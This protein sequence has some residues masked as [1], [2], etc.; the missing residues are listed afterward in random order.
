M[1]VDLLWGSYNRQVEHPLAQR[2]TVALGRVLAER[3]FGP[4]LRWLGV[5][6]VPPRAGK[7]ALPKPAWRYRGSR[8]E[9]LLVA[10]PA[11]SIGDLDD[12]E[13]MRLLIAAV[14]D[15]MARAL[16]LLD[17]ALRFDLT[18]ATSAVKECLAGKV[19]AL[20][21]TR[22][23][24]DLSPQLM[25]HMA[26][27]TRGFDATRRGWVRPLTHRL[28][29]VRIHR[30][31]G[32]VLGRVDEDDALVAELLTGALSGRIATPGYS[33]IYVNVGPDADRLRFERSAL[34]DWCENAYAVVDLDALKRLDARR[35]RRSVL[36]SCRQAL[37]ELA[38]VDHLD[39][40]EILRLTA[41]LDAEDLG[42]VFVYRSET[43]G[44]LTVELRYSLAERKDLLRLLRPVF[45]LHAMDRATGR[46][47]SWSVGVFDLW[48]LARQI[49][50]ITIGTRDIRIA[51]RQGSKVTEHRFPRDALRA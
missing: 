32:D 40:P 49:G 34:E 18:A 8:A 7:A 4:A 46:S 14:P 21:S 11:P 24:R 1:R 47:A 2:A 45:H 50:R 6:F 29:R 20:G 13:A 35:R 19:D 38:L 3:D 30:C 44:D 51:T 15:A 27:V 41:E 28:N 26:A 42:T 37:A 5:V 36:E 23:K 39:G 31:P 17:P 16:P 22:S 33:E 10:L 25:A 48:E 12:V 43:K 9:H